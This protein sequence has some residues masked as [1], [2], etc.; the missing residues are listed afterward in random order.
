M[1]NYGYYV[2]YVIFFY[3]RIYFFENVAKCF[4]EQQ[5]SLLQ[6][7]LVIVGVVVSFFSTGLCVCSSCSCLCICTFLIF[8]Y[9][10]IVFLYLNY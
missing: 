5:C 4:W 9:F 1:Y 8:I 2:L 10:C 6:D 7:V 3:T